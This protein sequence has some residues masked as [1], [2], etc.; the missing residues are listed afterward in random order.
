MVAAKKPLK[1]EG[2]GGINKLHTRALG[3]PSDGRNFWTRSGSLYTREGCSV[4][5]DTPFTASIKTLHSVSKVGLTNSIFL[6]EEG[7]NL[8]H[9]RDG[10]ATWTNIKNNVTGN[11]YNSCVWGTPY[12]DYYLLLM[13]GTQQLVYDITAGT[14]AALV[15]SEVGGTVPAF[16]FVT[17]FRGFVWGWGPNYADSNLIRF[18]GYDTNEDVSID[19]WPLDYAINPSGN[20]GEPV[21]AAHPINEEL[22]ILTD[23]GSYHI[24]GFSEENFETALAGNVGLYKTR[25]SARVGDYVLWLDRDQKVQAYSGTNSYTVSQPIDEYLKDE[26]FT[27]VYVVSLGKRFWLNF[28]GTTTTKS[29]VFDVEEKAWYIHEFPGVL[30]TGIYHGEYLSTMYSYYGMSDYRL[31]KLDPAVVTDFSTAITTEFTLGPI[32]IEG[33]KLKGKRFHI[34][35]DPKSDFDL[36]VY[37]QTD[38]EDE[39]GPETISF[40]EGNQVDAN[41]KINARKGKNLSVRV[42][43][44][45]KI[46][47]LQNATITVKPGRL[48]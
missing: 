14:I 32:N 11:K 12:G 48:K 40:E 20:P 6:L 30:T 23:K 25:C 27:N 29:Y 16:E 43:T 4:V 19:Y 45:D 17:T 47:E 41:V 22:F 39:V 46:D 7:V 8:W 1:I 5:A 35:A 26:T 33:R 38:Q 44:T 24:Y 42:T 13:S 37:S 34:T 2:F 10:L 36:E 18:C 3:Q 31:I 9:S 15:N 28:P 21:L